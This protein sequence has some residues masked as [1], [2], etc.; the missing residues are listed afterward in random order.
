MN[1]FAS[2]GE[3]LYTW[4]ADASLQVGVLVIALLILERF[5]GRWLTPRLRYAL[6]MILM[7]RL[8]LPG[9][10]EFPRGGL[11]RTIS[12]DAVVH[13]LPR[14]AR[15]TEALS[16][17]TERIGRAA[18]PPGPRRRTLAASTDPMTFVPQVWGGAQPE[19]PAP[20]ALTLR[21][22]A[23]WSAIAIALGLFGIGLWRALRFE[24]RL[25]RARPV[26]DAAVNELFVRCCRRMGIV[27]KVALLECESIASPALV[28]IRHPRV[29][30]PMDR[31]FALS[32]RSLELVLCH[33]LAHL[34]G[35]DVEVGLLLLALRSCFW[36][37]PLVW[38]A[39]ARLLTARE[40][41]RDWQALAAQ[42]GA[43]PDSYARTLLALAESRSLGP[44]PHA[45]LLPFHWNRT[46]ELKRR[47]Q[48]IHGFRTPSRAATLAGAGLAIALA[49]TS[50]TAAEGAA[51]KPASPEQGTIHVERASELPAWRLALDRALAQRFDLTVKDQPLG[52]LLADLRARTGINLVVQP[53]FLASHADARLS[54]HLEKVTLEEVLD[55]VCL[56][57]GD[58]QHGIGLQALTL[59]YDISL[60]PRELYIYQVRSLLV[61]EEEG[62][63]LEGQ[64][65]EM[66]QDA[67]TTPDESPWDQE[68]TWIQCW[69]GLLLVSQTSPV[70]ERVQAFLEFLASAGARPASPPEPWREALFAA[71][72][73]PAEIVVDRAR[74]GDVLAELS[75]AHAVAIQ[76]GPDW[77]DAEL[78]MELHGVDLGTV[79][80]WIGHELSLQ[81]RLAS[82][83]ILLDQK[84]GD[85]ELCLY[86]LG[87]IYRALPDS[88][89]ED[90]R[91]FLS[92]LLGNQVEPATWESNPLTVTRFWKSQMLVRQSASAQKGIAATLAAL[93]R[94]L[95]APASA[96]PEKKETGKVGA[97]STT[98]GELRLALFWNAA[99]G[100]VTRQ[101]G[102]RL[103]ED[104]DELQSLLGVAHLPVK[105]DAAP[106]VPWAELALVMQLCEKAQVAEVTFASA[107]ESGAK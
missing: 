22:A 84:G 4:L 3:R 87:P 83:A 5:A 46:H 27:R 37:H 73:R 16:L 13:W 102:N 53:D 77:S 58:G 17:D 1:T 98:A 28:G 104:D 91:D 96:P 95:G 100:K 38:V 61:A 80:A 47:I 103:V 60:P 42:P 59:G 79:L 9:V 8:A 7:L 36:F 63:D 45:T 78:T 32:G 26:A 105:I 40:A 31:T 35:R 43:S 21:S 34:R 20:V 93:E 92:D 48:M 94:S 55:V 33:E 18:A 10:P 15:A 106:E 86:D 30:L 39:S 41:S 72:A 11:G 51:Q 90:V 68:G 44:N 57:L 101:L 97:P 65:M 12:H 25:T 89:P 14:A 75:A 19:V 62:N 6:W 56:T 107:T 81:P 76:C 23:G 54:F 82:G 29:L 66:V 67:T 24:R 99:S 49:W 85:L 88:D 71:L 64:L 2:L 50:L 52:A 69:N 74:L 70:Q